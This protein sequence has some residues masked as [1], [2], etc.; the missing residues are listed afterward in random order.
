MPLETAKAGDPGPRR[1]RSGHATLT[2]LSLGGGIATALAAAFATSGLS[3]PSP[4]PAPRA[5]PAEVREILEAYCF[6]CHNERRLAGGLALDVLDVDAPAEAADRWEKVIRKL[7]TGT[8]PPGDELRPEPEEYDLVAEWL[9]TELDRAALEGAAEPGRTNPVHRLNRVEYNNAINDL[10]GLDVDVHSLLPGDETADGSFDNF[11]DAL[12]ITTTHMERYLSVARQVTRLAVGL[13]PS[14]PAVETFEV[15][16]HV[17]QDQRQSEELPFGSRGGTAVRYD[18]PVDGEYLIKIR[19]RRQYQDYLMGMGWPQQLD[20]RL[21]GAL[22]QRYTV[23]GGALEYRPA[24]ASYA[25]S[26]EPG[27]FGDPEWEEYMQMTGDAHLEARLRVEAGPRV[28]GVSFIREQW[29][30]EGLPQP[31][32]RGRV[33]TND[34]IYMDIASVHS[35]QIGGPYET[36]GTAG[37]TPS[38]ERIFTCRPT[39]GTPEEACATEILSTLARRAFR[40]PATDADVAT[41]LEFFHQGRADGGSFDAGIQLALERLVVD[42]EFLLRIYREPADAR[43]GDVYALDDLTVASRLSFFLWSG[44]PDEHLLSLAE[45]GRL[46]QPDVLEAET[47]RMLADPRAASALVEGFASQWLNLRLLP[48]KLADPDKYPDFDD[49]LLD[50]FKQETELFVANSIAEDLSIP[51]LLTADY[52]F[53]NERL[54]RFYGI[55]GVYGSRPRRVQLP[56]PDRRGGLLGQGGLM[57]LTA[58]PDR[59][60]P[61]LRG[62]WLLDNILG[63]DPPPPPANLDTSLEQGPDIAALG[64]RERFARHR[65][66]RLCASCHSLIDPLGYALE[67]FDAVGDWRDIDERG[68]PVDATG[69]LPS[70]A[71][72]DGVASLRDYLLEYDDQFVRTVTEK[73]MS[74]ALGRPLEYYDEPTVRRIVRDAEAGGYRWSAIVL[75]IVKSPA[76]LYRRTAEAI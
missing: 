36:D 27:S 65:S 34:Q 6:G 75:G 31:L 66:E 13:P 67:N 51:A 72:L 17:L 73:L 10:L 58:Y 2:V 38:R 35:V 42:P 70:G 30:P 15:P 57:A 25:G 26:G 53:A 44:V 28:I 24:A 1:A 5:A 47:R 19:L 37:D 12:S 59:T 7:R 3:S 43:P 52:T 40:R 22:V 45:E 16:L 54:A 9:E 71:L 20:L 50:A 48:E 8:M 11:A 62:K 76:F 64:I 63:A 18:F 74:Y 14:A 29:E 33:L 41:L 55:P 23:G 49:S 32:Q 68:L 56:D 60:S 46:L 4:A 61:V 21:E 69:T 39:P